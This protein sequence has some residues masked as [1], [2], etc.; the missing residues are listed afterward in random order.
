MTWAFSGEGDGVAG[1]IEVE[2]AQVHL[3]FNAALVESQS[4]VSDPLFSHVR[5]FSVGTSHGSSGLS[6]ESV[7]G[8]P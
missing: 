3:V 6:C 1:L 2:P 8:K 5:W 4:T 7:S